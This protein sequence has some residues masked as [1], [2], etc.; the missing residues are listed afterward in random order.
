MAAGFLISLPFHVAE[1]ARQHAPTQPAG[2]QDVTKPTRAPIAY[3]PGFVS[4]PAIKPERSTARRTGKITPEIVS[5]FQMA[6]QKAKADPFI[7]LAIAWTETRFD[8]LARNKHSS[9][10]GLLQ[11]TAVTWLTVIRDFGARHELA[12]YAN[13]IDTNKKMVRCRYGHLISER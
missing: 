9:A 8:P 4:R 7:L 10:R 3:K 12:H 1:A 11:F 13:A 6:Q 2:K 5:A